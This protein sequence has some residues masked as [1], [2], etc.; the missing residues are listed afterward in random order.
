MET[1]ITDLKSKKIP[2]QQIPQQQISQQQ[3]PQQQIPQQQML[4]QQ[5][6]QQ[7]ML[8][9]Q[10]PQQQMLQHQMLQPHNH[11]TIDSYPMDV[12]VNFSKWRETGVLLLLT[13]LFF[14]TPFQDTLTKTFP[15]LLS[16]N[17]GKHANMQGCMLISTLLVSS[18]TIYK[19]FGN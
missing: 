18:F 16:T 8:Q 1:A 6:P 7:Q 12:N 9:H 13:M 14:S 15:S 3:I 10:I 5:I 11:K 2:Q 4:Q 17:M 19:T